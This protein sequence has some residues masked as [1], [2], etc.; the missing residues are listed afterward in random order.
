MTT[1]PRG[2][3]NLEEQP[4]LWIFL[5]FKTSCLSQ[6]HWLPFP[7][8]LSLSASEESDVKIPEPKNP[9]LGSTSVSE[10]FEL[11]GPGWGKSLSR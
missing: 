11:P 6:G 4:L 9:I 2:P 10:G 5:W 1:D 7:R 8:G 3:Q